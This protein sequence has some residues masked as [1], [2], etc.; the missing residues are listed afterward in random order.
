MLI[1]GIHVYYRT[2]S[3]GTFHCPK[4][5]GDRPYRHRSGRRWFHLF[6]IP[7]IPLG[8]VGQYV[9][10]GVCRTKYAPQ[11]LAQ[12][13]M[14]Q[15]QAALP[16]GMRAAAITM[17]VAGDSGGHAARAKVIDTVRGAGMTGYD[18]SAV[19]SDIQ[20]VHTPGTDF[21]ARVGALAVQLAGP[22]KEWFLA[23][24]VR[25]GLADGALSDSERQAAEEVAAQLGMTRAQ[26]IGVI[27]LTEQGAS[28]AG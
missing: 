28:S 19:D 21:P 18:D 22:A 1:F 15:M 5:G 12:P 26:A 25:V 23:E 3:L 27:A 13:T 11:A 7:L 9:Q 2:I 24:I 10:C 6:F 4:C 16:A 8:H 17:L 20:A 14:A